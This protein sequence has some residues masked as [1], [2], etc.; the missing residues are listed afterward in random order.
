MMAR[1]GSGTYAVPTSF[2]TGTTIS[3]ADVNGNFSDL[4]SEM[5]NS[6]PRDGQAGMT[7]QLKAASGTAAAPGVTFG[8]DT[9][10]GLFLKSAN[11]V[12]IAAG[13]V[14]VGTIDSAGIKDANAVVVTGIPT[15]AVMMYGSIIPPAGW[16]SLSGTTI[17]NAASGA[18][19]RANADTSALFSFLWTNYGNAVC[20]VSSGRGASAAADFAANKTISV[21]DMRG[22]APF[23]MTGMGAATVSRLGT[24]LTTPNTIGSSGGTETHTLTSGE[25]PANIPNS[26]ITTTVTTTTMN[27]SLGADGV[28]NGNWGTGAASRTVQQIKLAA[29]SLDTL[30]PAFTSSSASST[31][32]TINAAGGGAHSNLPPAMVWPFIMKL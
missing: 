30:N 23:G 25:L 16:I 18:S 21:P 29:G 4:G 32:V 19:Q 9:D 24:I 7:G 28:T 3:S 31:S 20:A 27:T 10:S 11:T 8:S 15:G 1:N 13:G 17:G 2:T 22:R 6:L 5:T 26:A 14:E 12:G